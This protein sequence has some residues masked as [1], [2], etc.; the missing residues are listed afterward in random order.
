MKDALHLNT[1]TFEMAYRPYV[2]VKKIHSHIFKNQMGGLQAD[3]EYMNFGNVPA[4]NLKIE[5]EPGK[6]IM[7]SHEPI[8]IFPN[9]P[10]YVTFFIRKEDLQ[11]VSIGTK[12][13]IISITFQYERPDG[14]K[15]FTTE[16]FSYGSP[17]KNDFY[18]ISG[19]MKINE[20]IGK[21]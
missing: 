1:L 14:T 6:N 5:T 21:C 18:F 8:L 3:I 13:I 20:E 16:K 4:K 2:G 11:Q 15:Y 10:L 9:V 17:F 19:D 7:P 12:S